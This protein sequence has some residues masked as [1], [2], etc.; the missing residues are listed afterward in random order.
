MVVKD[1]DYPPYVDGADELVRVL[2]ELV[3]ALGYEDSQLCIVD[4]AQ[5]VWNKNGISLSQPL[6][7]SE[8]F[9]KV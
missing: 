9:I 3:D 6:L 7:T 4:V 2:W 1:T 5:S 8:W